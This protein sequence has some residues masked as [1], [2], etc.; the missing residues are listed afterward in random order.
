MEVWGYTGP[1]M[2]ERTNSKGV[3][4]GILMVCIN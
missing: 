1:E 4:T 2:A 3:G